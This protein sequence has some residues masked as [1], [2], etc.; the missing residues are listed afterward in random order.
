MRTLSKIACVCAVLASVLALAPAATSSN[1]YYFNQLWGLR[2]IG[3]DKAWATG[4]G[5]GITIAVVDTGVDL[6]HEDLKRNITAGY[7]EIELTFISSR[8][9]RVHPRLF[10]NDV[11]FTGRMPR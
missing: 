3:G 1:D 8:L 5:G 10:A 4:T 6:L 7:D 9:L 2:K 11:V